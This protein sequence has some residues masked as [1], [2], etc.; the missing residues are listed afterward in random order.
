MF[1]RFQSTIKKTLLLAFP[2]RATP[3]LIANW[4]IWPAY[5]VIDMFVNTDTLM[6]FLPVDDDQNGGLPKQSS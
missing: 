4:Y 1:I 5:I 6:S 3:V 2:R